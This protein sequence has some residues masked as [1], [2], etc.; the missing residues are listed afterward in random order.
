MD[1][2]LKRLTTTFVLLA[3]FGGAWMGVD[4]HFARATDVQAMQSQVTEVKILYLQ[5]ERRALLRQRFE[6]EVAQQ[7]RRL[8]PLEV[9]RLRD[10]AEELTDVDREIQRLQGKP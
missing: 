7:A 3:A 9:Q 8:T 2:W 10:L 5:S 4:S 1:T 6:L